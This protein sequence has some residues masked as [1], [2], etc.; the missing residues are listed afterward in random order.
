[1]CFGV[2]CGCFACFFF[3]L[4]FEWVLHVWRFCCIYVLYSCF[5]CVFWVDVLVLSLSAWYMC[6]LTVCL[7][8]YVCT[9]MSLLSHHARPMTHPPPPHPQ[10][11]LSGEYLDPRRNPTLSTLPYLHPPTSQDTITPITLWI[12]TDLNSLAGIHLAHAGLQFLHQGPGNGPCRLALLLNPSDPTHPPSS[13]LT[14]IV[15]A[16]AHAPSRRPKVLGF[17]VGLLEEVVEKKEGLL[18]DDVSLLQTALVHAEGAGLQSS[19]LKGALGEMESGV[20][21]PA[22]VGE[23]VGA[24]AA[25]VR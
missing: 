25:V 15:L 16:A 23:L 2:L 19:W 17:L 11:P 10:A 3:F 9:R 22:A 1:M 5:V 6:M 12:L 18:G 7:Q 4:Y 13:L 21:S 14:R 8:P 20:A 24:H